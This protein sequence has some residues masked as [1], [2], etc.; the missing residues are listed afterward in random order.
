MGINLNWSIYIC[1]NSSEAARG[2]RS[3]GECDVKWFQNS[4]SGV[5]KDRLDQQSLAP[6]I[7]NKM[8]NRKSI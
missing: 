3:D 6:Q 5:E 7:I 2:I 1:L 8:G 4:R